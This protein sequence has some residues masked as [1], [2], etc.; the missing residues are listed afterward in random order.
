[1]IS[2]IKEC[3]ALFQESSERFGNI[4]KQSFDLESFKRYP[5][6]GAFQL[7]RSVSMAEVIVVLSC[8][9][10]GE[11]CNT[12]SPLTEGVLKKHPQC[13]SSNLDR[14]PK[15]LSPFLYSS[16]SLLCETG[17]IVIVNS[18]RERGRFGRRGPGHV[19]R[20]R[21]GVGTIQLLLYHSRLF[22]IQ[23]QYSPS[24]LLPMLVPLVAS[25]P[26]WPKAFNLVEV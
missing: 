24:H 4:H 7:A 26:P 23:T 17:V 13:S 15:K 2:T 19:G 14:Q 22:M 18:N 21:G 5:P 9:Q 10:H 25:L 12:L 16:S 20:N 1:M 6:G 3:I 11:Y 8:H